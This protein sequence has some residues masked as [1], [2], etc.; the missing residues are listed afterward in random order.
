MKKPI[1]E[2]IMACFLLMSFFFLSREAARATLDAS[3]EKEVKE[4]V[5]VVDAGHGG[6]DPGMIGAGN[7]EEKGINLAVALKLKEE[8][9]AEGFQ[10]VMTRDADEGLYDD[11]SHNKKAQDM[12]RRIAMINEAKPLL[13]VSI[14]QNSYE[15]PAV[16]GPQV[17]YYQDSAQGE[18]L[19]A[20]LQEQLNVDLAV[21][22]PRV[23]KGNTSYYLLKRSES[24]L[25]IVECGFLTNP[26]EAALLQTEEYQRKVAKAIAG[27]IIK[28]SG[29]SAAHE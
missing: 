13:T 2:L 3:A 10:V 22:R 24:T 4:N 15:D 1:M 8:L 11:T 14:H 19:A 25:V 18:K 23:A 12:Q 16:Y 5:V 6:A 7:L 27:G 28:Y 9:E 17:F 29:G 20:V 26:D 21:A